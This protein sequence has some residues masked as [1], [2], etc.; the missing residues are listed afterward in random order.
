MEISYFDIQMFFA[1]WR[2]MHPI[3]KFVIMMGFTVLA[4]HIFSWIF[5]R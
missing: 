1:E 2:M 3:F 5:D 4:F